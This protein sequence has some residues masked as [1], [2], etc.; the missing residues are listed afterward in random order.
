MKPSKDIF[1]KII[2]GLIIAANI[3]FTIA[4]L[5]IFVRVGSEPSTL[6]AAWFTFTTGELWLL[7]KIKREKI[8]KGDREYD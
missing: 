5:V 2:I 4:V 8:K 3:M 7:A 1:S 6:I